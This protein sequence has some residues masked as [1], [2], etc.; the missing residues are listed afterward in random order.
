VSIGSESDSSNIPPPEPPVT[1]ISLIDR[2]DRI[3]G[4]VTTNAA[5]IQAQ[6]IFAISDEGVNNGA[7]VE[8][9]NT[10]WALKTVCRVRS[11]RQPL[12]RLNLSGLVVT[13]LS[14]PTGWIILFYAVKMPAHWLAVIAV[15]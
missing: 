5:N 10:V 1:G 2:N 15:S 8:D 9:N 11:F 4:E 14:I 3:M 6:A 7:A 12:H 13:G